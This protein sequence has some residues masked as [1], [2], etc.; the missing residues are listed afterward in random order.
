MNNNDN[1][2]NKESSYKINIIKPL[3]KDAKSA[4]ARDNITLNHNLLASPSVQKRNSF[5][6]NIDSSLI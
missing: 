3:E 5:Q 2:N 4:Y 6:G 1:N